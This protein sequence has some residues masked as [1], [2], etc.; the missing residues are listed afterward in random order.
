MVKAKEV[1]GLF[2]DFVDKLFLKFEE[3]INTSFHM[4]HN[5]KSD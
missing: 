1:V 3:L 4:G 2:E 5:H